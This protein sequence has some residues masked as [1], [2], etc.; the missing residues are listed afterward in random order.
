MA[1]HQVDH[2][3]VVIPARD[4]AL[5]IGA[6][7]DSVLTAAV[8]LPAPTTVEVVVVAD[9]CSDLTAELATAAGAHVLVVS[10]GNVGAARAIGCAWALDRTH[11]AGGLWLALTD[12]D[13]LVPPRWLL[14]Q[15][16]EAAGGAD[17]VLGTV[18]LSPDDAR[19]HP[20][21]LRRY[22]QRRPTGHDHGHVHGAN[23]GVRATSYVEVGGFHDLPLHEDVD[24]VTR[25]LDGGATAVWLEDVAVTT[26]ARHLSRVDGGV[27]A[28]LADEGRT[29]EHHVVA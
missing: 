16:Q 5:T 24:L 12:A 27:A 15:V 23:L 21:W 9:G 13:S 17:L 19:R 2:V 1:E 22:R 10:E 26:S 18:A 14:R 6:A 7:V 8:N 25:L 20:R 11:D 28:D 4:E 3:V 29:E